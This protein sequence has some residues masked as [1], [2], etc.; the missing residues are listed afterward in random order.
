MAAKSAA[1][2]F[3]STMLRGL[4]TALLLSAATK[5]ASFTPR[6]PPHALADTTDRGAMP[7]RTDQQ[8]EMKAAW[9][10]APIRLRRTHDTQPPGFPWGGTEL[11][12]S[13]ARIVNSTTDFPTRRIENMPGFMSS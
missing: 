6:L 4:E 11:P 10:A 5:A 3:V 7:R 1:A 8:A 9:S 2:K 13:K 12:S